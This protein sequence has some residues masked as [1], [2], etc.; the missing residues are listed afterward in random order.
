MLLQTSCVT[1]ASTRIIWQRSVD[2]KRGV[3]YAVNHTPPL[4]TMTS[5]KRKR[6][7]R[8]RLK[9]KKLLVMLQE[10]QMATKSQ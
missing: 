4:F 3:K 1:V 10:P 7:L 9:S 6:T 8:K 2:I 5:G